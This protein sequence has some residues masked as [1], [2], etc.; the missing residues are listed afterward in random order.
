MS[1]LYHFKTFLSTQ[2]LSNPSKNSAH[3]VFSTQCFGHFI[4]QSF[5]VKSSNQ[6]VEAKEI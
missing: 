3:H 1:F 5:G 6:K 4:S 2:S